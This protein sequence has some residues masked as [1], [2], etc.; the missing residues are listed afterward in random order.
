MYLLT[1]AEMRECDRR[2][3]EDRDVPGPVLMERAG[4]GLDRAIRARF[5]HLNRRRIWI[6]CGRG[7]NGGDGLVLARLL[8][9]D[10]FNPR[11][12][13]TDP[14]AEIAGDAALQV[15]PAAAHGEF[16]S[17]R[18]LRNSRTASSGSAPTICSSTRSSG[19]GS[20]EA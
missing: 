17:S 2:T 20:R 8:H 7:N 18:S 19:R 13:L 9:D 14:A 11:V 1:S 12:L 10:G 16:P 4:R 15:P 3:I 5:P 6:V